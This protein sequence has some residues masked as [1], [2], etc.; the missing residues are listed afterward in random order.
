MH[1]KF[2]KNINAPNNFYSTTFTIESLLFLKVLRSIFKKKD[3]QKNKSTG[4]VY[5]KR[6]TRIQI[7]RQSLH[8]QKQ[9][10][11]IN[12][13]NLHKIYLNEDANFFLFSARFFLGLI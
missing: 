3:K 8:K 6:Q 2:K 5:T 7:T 1:G 11:H 12:R 10:T 13:Q 4:K 9:K